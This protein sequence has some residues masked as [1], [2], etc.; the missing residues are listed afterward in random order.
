M[1]ATPYTIVFALYLLLTGVQGLFSRT[2]WWIF[3]TNRTHAVIELALAAI[4]LVWAARGP[5]RAAYLM[6]VG[7]LLVVVG[8]M[9]LIPATEAFIVGLLNVNEALA[10]AN[11]VIGGI[12]IGVGLTARLPRLPAEIRSFRHTGPMRVR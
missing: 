9:R 8:A 4:A 7:L 5:Q 12:S 10:V 11:L 6:V 1:R 3:T 2:A